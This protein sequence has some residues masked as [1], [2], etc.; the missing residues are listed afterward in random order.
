MQ[1]D[2]PRTD[3]HPHVPSGLQHAMSIDARHVRRVL[4]A[5]KLQG[6]DA[7][8]STGGLTQ[9]PAEHTR[10]LPAQF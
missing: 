6:T 1:P 4:Q 3:S 9:A 7:P 8:L 5:I 2:G 10:P